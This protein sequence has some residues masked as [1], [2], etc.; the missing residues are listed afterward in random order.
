MEKN[1]NRSQ[2]QYAQGFERGYLLEQVMPALTAQITSVKS[3]HPSIQGIRDGSKLYQLEKVRDASVNMRNIESEKMTLNFSNDWMKGFNQG[4][5][6]AE[7]IPGIIPL[8]MVA[9]EPGKPSEGMKG[10][11][12][13]IER[14]L[15]DKT[16]ELTQTWGKPD[17]KSRYLPDPD[18]P[19]DKDNDPD[20][21]R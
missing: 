21:D 20:K 9:Q 7:K 12:L 3:E 8:L 11:R 13:G 10:F 15:E 19:R 5:A 1:S 6:I 16:H 18:K 17:K 14:C 2:E 4:Y